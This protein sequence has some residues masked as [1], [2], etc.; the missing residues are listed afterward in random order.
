QAAAHQAGIDGLVFHD[1]RRSA[2]TNMVNAGVPDL[3]VMAISGHRSLAVLKRYFI[4]NTDR[5]QEAL[6]ATRAYVAAR[7]RMADKTRTILPQS[8][9]SS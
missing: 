9:L 6:E 4:K 2:I 3:V 7:Q 8:G 1:L 5:M